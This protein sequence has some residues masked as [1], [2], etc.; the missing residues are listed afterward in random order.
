MIIPNDFPLVEP[1]N[2]RWSAV[3]TWSV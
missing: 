3:Q 1:K 2:L